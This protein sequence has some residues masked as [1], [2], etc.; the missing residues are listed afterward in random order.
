MI[1]KVRGKKVDVVSGAWD[2]CPSVE[3]PEH[4]IDWIEG[5]VGKEAAEE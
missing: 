4:V 1:E 3:K 5:V 2:H